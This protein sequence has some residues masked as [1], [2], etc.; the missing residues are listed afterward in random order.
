M[1]QKEQM[2]QNFGFVVVVLFGQVFFFLPFFKM[3]KLS[4]KEDFFFLFFLKEKVGKNFFWGREKD[5]FVQIFLFFAGGGT[6]GERRKRGLSTP[7]L[8]F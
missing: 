7:P 1:E 3:S 5:S 4:K 6:S 2:E 8:L